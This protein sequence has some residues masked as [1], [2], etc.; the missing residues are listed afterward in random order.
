MW[1]IVELVRDDHGNNILY[2]TLTQNNQQ[3]MWLELMLGHF[4]DTLDAWNCNQRHLTENC[5]NHAL[6]W[7]FGMVIF[8]RIFVYVPLTRQ[9]YASDSSN[10]FSFGFFFLSLKR[11][12][13]F[14]N[15]WNKLTNKF[16]NYENYDKE[17]HKHLAG[18]SDSEHFA[19]T[20]LHLIENCVRTNRNCILFLIYI[21]FNGSR[22]PFKIISFDPRILM[23]AIT[24]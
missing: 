1:L 4:F 9:R 17:Q 14:D 3:S 7:T 11:G 13:H 21:T 24:G 18:H 20:I 2:K 23:E 12:S 22:R 19:K 15:T 5:Y 6:N 8:W 10:P 16:I